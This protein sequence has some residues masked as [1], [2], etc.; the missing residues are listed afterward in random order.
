MNLST[1]TTHLA[2]KHTVERLLKQ[3]PIGQNCGL[4]RQ[5][6]FG[7]R[8][9]S[10]EIW[11]TGFSTRNVWRFEAGGLSRLVTHHKCHCNYLYAGG[12]GYSIQVLLYSLWI[13]LQFKEFLSPNLAMVILISILGV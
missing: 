11:G 13:W 2:K 5:V 7:D 3:C 1:E 4:S 12:G 10:T 8:F 9:N 6:V